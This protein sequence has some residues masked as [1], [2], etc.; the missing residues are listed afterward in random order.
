MDWLTNIQTFID[1]VDYQSFTKAADKR[2]SSPAV[3]SRRIVWLEEQLGVTLMQRTTRSLQLTE[4]GRQLYTK[5]KQWLT[6]LDEITQQLQNQQ[7]VLKGPLYVT[8][9]Y[10]FAD[11]KIVSTLIAEFASQHPQ[12]ELT[13]NFTNETL[14]LIKEDVDVALRAVPYQGVGYTS[15]KIASIGLGVYGSPTYFK[16]HGIPKNL[17]E[18]SQHNCLL[19][20]T[21]GHAEWEFLHGEKVLVSGNLKM[22]ATRALIQFAIQGQGLIYTLDCYVTPYIAN[23]QLQPILQKKWQML[24]L[25]LVY[26]NKPNI[27][28]RVH[29][30]V[31]YMQQHNLI[32]YMVTTN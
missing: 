30:F 12:I 24:N 19:H 2:F 5:G 21:I 27:P 25:Y 22:N 3:F 16:K 15:Y 4:E 23:K 17:R 9:P 6:H 28:Q 1:V 32:S 11:T 31:E 8:M 20:T 18:L 29:T 13:L 14:D 7:Q 10:S 26:K